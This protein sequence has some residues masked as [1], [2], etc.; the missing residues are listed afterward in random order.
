[1]GLSANYYF[2]FTLPINLTKD[3]QLVITFPDLYDN[4]LGDNLMS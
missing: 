3:Y 2:N 1:M 4:R